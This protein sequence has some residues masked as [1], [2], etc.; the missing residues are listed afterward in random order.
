MND[1]CIRLTNLPGKDYYKGDENILKIKLWCQITDIIRR[2]VLKNI[3]KE[4]KIDFLDK[5]YQI[6]DITFGKNNVNKADLLI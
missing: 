1:F 4:Q 5:K 3:D 2:Q 6:F